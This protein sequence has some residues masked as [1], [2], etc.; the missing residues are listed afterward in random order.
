MPWRD[1]PE[2]LACTFILSGIRLFDIRD[3]T[4]PKE[5]AYFNGPAVPRPVAPTGGTGHGANY[6]MSKPVLVPERAEV[7]YSDGNK[8]F[9]SLRVTNGVWPFG[10]S[11]PR[12]GLGAINHVIGTKGWDVL[13]GTP[14]KDIL[15][16]LGG[17][18]RIRGGEGWDLI[19]GGPGRD[20]LIGGRGRDRCHGGPGGDELPRT[21]DDRSF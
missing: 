17:R 20:A 6:A 19:F 9:Y 21:C 12:Y 1:D 18:D 11:C 13:R 14:E 10:R 4:N 8:G 16:G 15:C 3:P 7:W 5:I 2:V